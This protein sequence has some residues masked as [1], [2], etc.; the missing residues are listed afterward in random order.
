MDISEDE[1]YARSLQAQEDAAAAA[2]AELVSMRMTYQQPAVVDWSRAAARDNDLHLARRL[3]QLEVESAARTLARD[4]EARRNPTQ[5]DQEK[6]LDP[7]WGSFPSR[8]HDGSPPHPCSILCLSC[9]PCFVPPC[10]SLDST[11]FA[12]THI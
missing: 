5:L 10:C 1:A 2:A 7:I 9:C 11:S 12:M 4:E 6:F 8:N 3:Q